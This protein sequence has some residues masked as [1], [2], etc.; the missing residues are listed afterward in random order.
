MTL[1]DKIQ[2]SSESISFSEVISHVDANFDFTPTRFTNGNAV[3]EAGQNNGSCKIFAFAKLNNLTEKQI[4]ALFGD[5]YQLDVLGNPEGSDHQNIRNFMKS[6]WK[7]I[8]LEGKAL[9]PR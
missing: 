5:Y 2:H 4:L 3:N 7:G 6:G 9:S 1:L 8:R